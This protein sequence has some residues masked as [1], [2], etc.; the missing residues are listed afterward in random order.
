MFAL[1]NLLKY[2]IG[3][4]V[5]P[6]TRVLP[7]IVL[8]QLRFKHG[9][10]LNYLLTLTIYILGERKFRGLQRSLYLNPTTLST[11]RLWQTPHRI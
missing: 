8:Y 7:D 5:F 6:P 9:F 4:N 11:E 10:V 2:N 3:F 1:F